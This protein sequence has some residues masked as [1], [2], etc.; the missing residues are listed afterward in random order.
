MKAIFWMLVVSAMFVTG[1]DEKPTT[2]TTSEK[3]SDPNIRVRESVGGGIGP[4]G[5]GRSR[6]YE[7]PATKAPAWAQPGK[8]K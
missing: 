1:C 5:G 3:P 7:G 8:S 2:K 6:E 4:V